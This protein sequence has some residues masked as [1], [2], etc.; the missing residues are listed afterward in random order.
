MFKIKNI[1]LFYYIYLSKM[2]KSE[3]NYNEEFDENTDDNLHSISIKLLNDIEEILESKQLDNQSKV[4]SLSNVLSTSNIPFLNRKMEKEIF[5][6]LESLRKKKKL[7]EFMDILQKTKIKNSRMLFILKGAFLSEL[8]ILSEIKK[9]KSSLI[10]IKVILGYFIFRLKDKE[11]KKLE[12]FLSGKYKSD[13]EYINNLIKMLEKSKN[14]YTIYIC[15]L[16]LS[17]KNLKEEEKENLSKIFSD[18]FKEKILDDSEKDKNLIHERILSKFL[19][20]IKSNLFFNEIIPG[21]ELLLNRNSKNILFVYNILIQKGIECTDDFVSNILFS[22]FN[23]FFFPKDNTN[24][25][26]CFSCFDNIA[27]NSN[28]IKILEILLNKTFPVDQKSFYRYTIY[29][30]VSVFK[31]KNSKDKNILF[32]DKLISN[33]ILY[34]LS[35]FSDSYSETFAFFFF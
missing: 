18:Y 25:N 28:R 13:N 27:N 29:Y 31:I 20:Y 4:S 7:D 26:L 11:Q 15:G 1:Y 24:D 22:K 35:H 2:S 16:A 19:K 6:I 9:E 5:N 34:I 10:M 14:I 23:S 33:T 30:I 12:H 3:I 21:C 17:I 32:S 8:N